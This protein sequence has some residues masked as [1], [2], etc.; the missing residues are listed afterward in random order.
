M[1]SVGPV[2]A[3]SELGLQEDDV[4]L[5]VTSVGLLSP[6]DFQPDVV[7]GMHYCKSLSVYRALEWMYVDSLRA[8][9]P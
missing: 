3:L 1:H 6:V 8:H 4:G 5:H 9:A 7:A 2:W